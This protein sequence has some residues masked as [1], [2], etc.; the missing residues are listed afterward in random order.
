MTKSPSLALTPI[1]ERLRVALKRRLDII[2]DHK[3]RTYNPE[4][5]L[6]QLA[7]AS[8]EIEALSKELGA[9]APAELRHFLDRMSFNKALEWIDQVWP[10][11]PPMPLDSAQDR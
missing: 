2:A 6:Q 11:N 9:R 4:G 3:L 10:E 1:Y 8:R 5:Q 7:E